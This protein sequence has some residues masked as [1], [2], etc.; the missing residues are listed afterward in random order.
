[1]TVDAT[2]SGVV[3]QECQQ[4][5]VAV[6]VGHTHMNERGIMS[7]SLMNVNANDADEAPAFST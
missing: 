4:A 5:L 2:A 7:K 6:H 3:R 1:M